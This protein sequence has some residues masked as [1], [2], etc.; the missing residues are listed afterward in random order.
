MPDQQT[1]TSGES[2]DSSTYGDNISSSQEQSDEEY[3][4]EYDED[5]GPSSADAEDDQSRS[6]SLS[7]TRRA[8][9]RSNSSGHSD[10]GS[11]PSQAFL[12]EDDDA[13]ARPTSEKR[14]SASDGEEEASA[15]SKAELD[16][17][18]QDIVIRTRK[19]CVK[20]LTLTSRAQALVQR[21]RL[22]Q[23]RSYGLYGS[24][25]ERT[26]SGER[27]HSTVAP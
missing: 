16:N 10:E 7:E 13:S 18:L 9:Y 8:Q 22:E 5:C 24:P 23:I 11:M 6:T 3:D 21:I 20:S 1:Q 4:E 27:G 2:R 19:A 15:Q 17:R 12:E 26:F 14:V 25:P